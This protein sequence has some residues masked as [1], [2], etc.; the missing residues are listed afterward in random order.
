M[1]SL[2][3]R[4]SVRGTRIK[5]KRPRMASRHTRRP[6]SR[7][8]AEPAVFRRIAA[9][10][11]ALGMTRCCDNVSRLANLIRQSR[12]DGVGRRLSLDQIRGAL[13]HPSGHC[14]TRG[15]NSRI[16]PGEG[17]RPIAPIRIISAK[18]SAGW[19]A[20]QPVPGDVR[21]ELTRR[22]QAESLKNTPL[23]GDAPRQLRRRFRTL[24]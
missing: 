17:W 22:R 3:I 9:G 19:S 13:Q 14:R 11:P 15:A 2:R 4:S 24:D 7:L 8:T 20:S 16:S 21:Q 6:L 18:C 5:L 1:I 12:G 23:R 10:N